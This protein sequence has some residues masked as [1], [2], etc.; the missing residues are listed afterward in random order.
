VQ[1]NP[2]INWG[3]GLRDVRKRVRIVLLSLL[4]TPATIKKRKHTYQ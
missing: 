2:H 3:L 1:A 4:L